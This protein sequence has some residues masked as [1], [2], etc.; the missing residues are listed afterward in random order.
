M[1]LF[2]MFKIK[3]LKNFKP[4]YTKVFEDLKFWQQ[5]GYWTLWTD[6]N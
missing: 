4:R 5:R 6:T 2:R 1:C 3:V